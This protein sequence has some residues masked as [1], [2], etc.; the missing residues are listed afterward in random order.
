[1]LTIYRQGDSYLHRIDPRTKLLVTAGTGILV[2]L[3]G[4][5][6]LGLLSVIV[7]LLAD[8]AEIP[9]SN[10]LRMLRPMSIFFAAIFLFHLLL[11]HGSSVL[12][13]AIPVV[14]F[15]LLI[16]FT[17]ILLHTTSQSELNTALIYFLR[18]L[19]VFGTGIAFMVGVAITFI[20]GLLLDK[21]TITRAQAARGCKPKGLNG[22]IALIVPLMQRSLRKA[23]E[24]SDALESR[25]YHRDKKYYYYEKMLTR[26]DHILIWA[27]MA[28]T[29]LWISV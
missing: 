25:C 6:K 21:E 8:V 28:I 13:A 26:K 7:L 16:L 1:M 9:I 14:R 17:T 10:L 27:F 12:A 4:P 22:F 15:V 20:Q 11:T 23:D 18:P 5:L 29:I 24:L 19:G 2:Y 3:S